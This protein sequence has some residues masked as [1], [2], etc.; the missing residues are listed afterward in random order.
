MFKNRF[1]TKLKKYLDLQIITQEQYESICQYEANS[2]SKESV[3]KFLIFYF[4]GF[5]LIVFFASNWQIFTRIEKTLFLLGILTCGFWG[6]LRFLHSNI[7]YARLFGVLT[8]FAFGLNLLL[9]GQMYHLGDNL[10]LA[11]SIIACA[12]L[13]LAFSLGGRMLYMQSIVMLY[14]A[15][16]YAFI[17]LSD[18]AYGFLFFLPFG[19]YCAYRFENPS[20]TIL[21][22]I[23]IFIFAFCMIKNTSLAMFA[24]IFTSGLFLAQKPNFLHSAMTKRL[25]YLFLSFL[26]LLFGTTQYQLEM[27]FQPF[28]IWVYLLLFIPAIFLWIIKQKFESLLFS[29]VVLGLIL[30]VF[31]P[32]SY[33]SFTTFYCWGVFFGLCVSLILQ[34]YNI[35]GMILLIVFSISQYLS[36]QD[37]YLST[38]IFFGI[39][40]VC[41]FF[42]SR[43]KNA[44][45][46]K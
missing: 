38:G 10:P 42:I 1:L 21:N 9:I 18:L 34:N 8:N 26:L 29:L 7:F 17:T 46:Q 31:T 40:C 36:I 33:K 45:T 5:C 12:S 20:I 4:L 11:L 15:F 35:W 27:F 6:I 43:N 16:F 25:V 24:C 23:N 13:L 44:I 19:F 14:I 37:D 28:K 2:F 32:F 22:Y 41:L 39:C 30:T 3:L